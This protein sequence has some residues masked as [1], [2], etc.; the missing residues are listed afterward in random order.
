MD[1]VARVAEGPI[2]GVF[3]CFKDIITR[4]TYFRMVNVAMVSA[5]ATSD[6]D[7]PT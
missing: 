7:T 5:M 2:G 4:Q 3:L 1:V 6:I